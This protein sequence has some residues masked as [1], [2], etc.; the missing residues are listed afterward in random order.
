MSDLHNLLRKGGKTDTI[1][2]LVKI[3]CAGSSVVEQEPFKLVVVGSTPTQRTKLDF[4]I[5]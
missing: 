1:S 4:A 2:S 3:L 5:F